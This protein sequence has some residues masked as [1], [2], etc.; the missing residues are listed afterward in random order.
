MVVIWLIM[1]KNNLVS[2]WANPSEKWWLV[3]SSVGMIIPFPT[4]WKVIK[5]HGSSHHQPV[6]I[7]WDVPVFSH[8]FSIETSIFF[9]ENPIFHRQSAPLPLPWFG[10]HRRTRPPG[11]PESHLAPS[12]ELGMYQHINKIHMYICILVCILYIE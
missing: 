5:I 9:L 4:E 12:T 10:A 11:Y 3:S 2:G 7:W 1:V 8:E 6:M